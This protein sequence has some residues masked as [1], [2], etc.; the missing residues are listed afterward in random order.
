VQDRLPM[1]WREPVPTVPSQSANA[2]A[3]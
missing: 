2:E 3:G 1:Q